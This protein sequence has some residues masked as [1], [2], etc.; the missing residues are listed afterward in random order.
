[1]RTNS[2]T[3]RLFKADAAQDQ[4]LFEASIVWIFRAARVS[5]VINVMPVTDA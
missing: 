1:M 2:V 4:A 3:N 5:C